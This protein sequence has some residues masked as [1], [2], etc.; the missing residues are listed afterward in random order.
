MPE[1][2]TTEEIDALQR[3]L[4]SLKKESET[5]FLEISSD[6]TGVR[7]I[8]KEGLETLMELDRTYVDDLD[9][10]GQVLT[11]IDETE[12]QQE[13]KWVAEDAAKG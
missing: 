11:Q 1:H 2:I 9:Q 4:D 13:A 12:A 7:Q 3:Q 10:L 6:A 8:M 5:L